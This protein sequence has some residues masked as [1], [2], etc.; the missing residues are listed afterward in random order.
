MK[1][2]IQNYEE[3]RIIHPID[4]MVSALN[5]CI[6]G[7]YEVGRTGAK[8]NGD[9]T[10]DATQGLIIGKRKIGKKKYRKKKGNPNDKLIF[11]RSDHEKR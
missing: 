10:F 7:G 5:Y 3:I 11:E 6:K 9:G 1:I 8:P 4:E 2:Q